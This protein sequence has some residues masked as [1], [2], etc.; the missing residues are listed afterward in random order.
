[1][2]E[3]IQT[4]EQVNGGEE[5]LGFARQKLSVLNA[6]RQETPLPF[7][8]RVYEIGSARI[9]VV[10]ADS[11]NQIRIDAAPGGFIC[12]PRDRTNPGGTMPG[13]VAIT[14]TFAYPLVDDDRG[15]RVL[16]RDSEDWEVSS[17]VEN[18]GNVDWKGPNEQILTWRGPPSRYFPLDPSIPYP[19]LTYLDEDLIT[20]PAY[21]VFGPNIYSA[22]EILATL[23]DIGVTT[24][25]VLGAAYNNG[26]LVA[27]VGTNYRD[28][29]NPNGGTGGFFYE[30]WAFVSGAWTRIGFEQGVR[31]LESWF[32]N[33]SGNEAQTVIDQ[34]VRKVVI[35]SDFSSVSFSNRSIWIEPSSVAAVS[36][37]TQTDVDDIG[38]DDL[39]E[40]ASEGGFSRQETADITCTGKRILA[41]DYKGD[42]E[43]LALINIM[44]ACSAQS[45]ANKQG[46]RD[47]SI[48]VPDLPDNGAYP[49]EPL[50]YVNDSLVTHSVT[51]ETQGLCNPVITSVSCGNVVPGTMQITD[52]SCCPDGEISGSAEDS[53]GCRSA[54]FSFEKVSHPPLGFEGTWEFR[55][56]QG[57]GINCTG[58]QYAP[59]E[60]LVLGSQVAGGLYSENMSPSWPPCGTGVECNGD[61]LIEF[62]VYGSYGNCVWIQW[63]AGWNGSGGK[64]INYAVYPHYGSYTVDP[65]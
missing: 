4:H 11:G 46:Y 44:S 58:N 14:P 12:H 34:T 56:P 32:F 29:Q 18:Y 16:T 50:A 38:P 2:T 23:P 10:S 19:G 30:V 55:Y 54:E 27:V 42:V 41:V 8:R 9:T 61:M 37:A 17:D 60:I 21:S 47:Y 22:G 15:S 28:V 45:D 40:I 1:M 64:I 48:I 39:E 6:A 51:V 57:C 35:A 31:Q 26:T 20:G 59:T 63:F 53:N 49:Q 43:V 7:M 25:K 24:T 52:L 3:L 62:K 36:T 33:A 5:Y 13:G 65:C